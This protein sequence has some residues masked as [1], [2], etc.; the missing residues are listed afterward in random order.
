MLDANVTGYFG[1]LG[2]G[3]AGFAIGVQRRDQRLTVVY[4]HGH[5]PGWLRVPHRQ[6]QFRGRDGRPCHVWRSAAAAF[7]ALR[8]NR[9]PALRRLRRRG[10]RHAGSEVDGARG[11][12]VD[13]IAARVGGHL[14]SRAVERSRPRGCRPISSTSR[15]STAR[16]RLPDAARLAIRT[17]PRRR[18]GP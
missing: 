13:V 7:A 18:R 3:P 1:D 2:G 16:R 11:A 14:V 12:F 17:W 10:W 8:G 15:I 4:G 6:S 5:A 9:R